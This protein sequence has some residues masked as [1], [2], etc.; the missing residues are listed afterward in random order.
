MRT[1]LVDG[2]LADLLQDVRFLY[3]YMKYIRKNADLYTRKNLWSLVASLPTSRQQ[4]VFALLVPS[5]QQ[6]WNRLLTTCNR[7]DGIIRLVIQGCSN[8]SEQ[9]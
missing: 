9:S 2:L 7:L 1:Q 4:V 8:K 3:V 6:V 5:S